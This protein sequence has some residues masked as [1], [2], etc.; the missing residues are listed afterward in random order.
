MDHT[1]QE[2][3]K[4]TKAYAEASFPSSLRNMTPNYRPPVWAEVRSPCLNTPLLTPTVPERSL[5]YFRTLKQV[6]Y[7]R[8]G[9]I[10]GFLWMEILEK[11]VTSET[12]QCTFDC[13]CHI[14]TIKST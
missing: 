3:S 4:E 11:D 1:E 14:T 7:R 10:Y 6:A 8:N 9:A 13:R 12:R 5:E 2:L